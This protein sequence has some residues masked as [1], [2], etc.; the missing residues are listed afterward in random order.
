[1][2]IINVSYIDSGL[3]SQVPVIVIQS[4]ELGHIV[5]A[6]WEINR[7]SVLCH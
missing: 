3:L 2:I 7:S 1:M 6:I 5:R 4:I